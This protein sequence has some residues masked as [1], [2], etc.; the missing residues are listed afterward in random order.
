MGILAYFVEKSCNVPYE[1]FHLIIIMSTNCHI[2][3]GIL[4]YFVEKLFLL[5]CLSKYYTTGTVN[6]FLMFSSISHLKST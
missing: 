5:Y 2:L 6:S 4:A 1:S 3:M